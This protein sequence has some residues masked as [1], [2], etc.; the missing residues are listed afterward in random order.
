MGGGG[1]LLDSD[2]AATGEGRGR[3]RGQLGTRLARLGAR[4]RLGPHQRQPTVEPGGDDRG[5]SDSGEVTA[6]LGP[7]AARGA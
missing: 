2:E 7:Q 5:I 1:G 3:G 4:M 6:S